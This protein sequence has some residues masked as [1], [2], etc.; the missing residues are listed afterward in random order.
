MVTCHSAYLISEHLP[1][2]LSFWFLFGFFSFEFI[3][4]FFSMFQDKPFP[5]G[6]QM[7]PHCV[8]QGGLCRWAQAVGNPVLSLETLTQTLRQWAGWSVPPHS[9]AEH[10][11]WV[12]N[13]PPSRTTEAG[14]EGRVVSGTQNSQFNRVRRAWEKGTLVLTLGTQHCPLGSPKHFGRREVICHPGWP[15]SQTCPSVGNNVS[16]SQGTPDTGGQPELRRQRGM[17]VVC[18]ITSCP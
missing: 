15:S 10:H 8:L 17:A 6:I 11:S 1:G 3:V 12:P 2:S 4:I 14:F 5:L 9:P 16:D 18:N 13:L 7:F